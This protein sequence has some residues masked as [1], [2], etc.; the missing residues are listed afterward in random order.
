MH[1]AAAI[2]LGAALQDVPPVADLA[3]APEPTPAKVTLTTGE[4]LEVEILEE[5][6]GAYRLQHPVLG[7]MVLERDQVTGVETPSTEAEAPKSPWSGSLSFALAGYENVNSNLELRIGG[8]LKRKTDVDELVLSARYFFGVTNGETQNN[9]FQATIDYKRDLANPRWFIFGTGQYEY[10]QFQSWEHRLSGWGGAGYRFVKDDELDLNGRL[11]FGTSYEFG[12]PSRLIPE[13]LLGIDFEWRISDGQK[14]KGFF[15]FYPDVDDI[16][17]YRFSTEL[18][19]SVKLDGWDGVAFEAGISDQ[20]QSQVAS[21]TRN[22]FRYF[23]GL[24]YE[25]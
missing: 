12:P 19:W 6:P 15:T 14:L 17:E 8:E 18:K 5:T 13:A 16:A 9:N 7:E 2:L 25:F 22:D 21:G 23:A 10:D 4:V 11:G 1:P 3:A 20:Y 24:K